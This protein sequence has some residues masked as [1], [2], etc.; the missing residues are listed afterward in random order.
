M[1]AA[2]LTP[3]AVVGIG[4]SA[5]GLQAYTELLEALPANTGMTF[6]IVQHMAAGHESFLSTLLGRIASMPV[7]EVLDGPQ[8][9]PNTIY[10]IPPNRTM[11]IT[12]GC[13][14]LRDRG[15]GIHFSVDIFFQ[16]LAMSHG[17]RAIGVVL[18][19]TGS[20]GAKGIEA[21]K[22]GGGTTFA[23]D[24]SAQQSGMPSSAIHTGCVDFVL[25]PR[26]IALEIATLAILPELAFSADPVEP[27]EDVEPILEIVR[28]RVRIDFSQYKENTLHRRI[29][30]RMALNQRENLTGYAA[31]LREK[32]TEV[33]ALAQD[34]LISVTSFFRDPESFEALKKT[35]FPRMLNR[36]SPDDTIR[37]WVVGCSTGEEP[38]SLAIALIEAMDATPLRHPIAVFG[39]DVNSQAIERAR[40]GWYPK[41][42]SEDISEE[43]LR[44][45]FTAV[46]GGYV[47]SKLIRDLCV[48]A[49]HNAITDPPF[50]R[51]DLVSCRNL[52]IYF[53]SGPQRKLLPLLHYALKPN[54]T[55][56][57]GASESINNYRDLFDQE[58][59]RHKIYVKRPVS[60]R[61]TETVPRA[62]APLPPATQGGRKIVRP[63]RDRQIER[64]RSAELVALKYFAPAGVLVDLD[65]EIHQFRGD[66]SPYVN[67]AEGRASLNL[68]KIAREG[69]FVAIRACL[70]HAS[71]DAA[72]LRNEGVIVK[73]DTGLTT[74]S[75][76]VIPVIYPGSD[77]RSAWI[78]FDQATSATLL[79]SDGAVLT[80]NA[81]L[82]ANTAH[83][84]T[85]LTDEL[86]ATRDHLEATIQEQEA[87]NE[88][89]QAANEEVQSSNEE[90]QSTNEELETSKEEIQSSNEEL[91]TV[92]DEL[93]LRNDEL[94]RANND[95]L[96]LFS[97]VQMA[98][99]MVWPDLRIRRFTPLAQTIFNI[100]PADVG[101]SIADMNHHIDIDDFTGLLREALDHGR[102]LEREVTS[103]EGYHYLLRL[104]PYR[105]QD[106]TID[107]AIVLLVDI[108]TLAQ[109]QA[110]LR[111]RV[112]ELA[113]S[114]RH[115]NEFLA[116]L[117]HE[118]RNPLAP[119]RNAVQ[120]LNRSPGDA[121]HTAKARGLIDRQVHH[122]SAPRERPAGCGALAERP[123]QITEFHAGSALLRRACDRPHAA[124]FRYQT[125]DPESRTAQ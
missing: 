12:D 75:I 30:R 87:A 103:K 120:I 50:S 90:L 8:V 22:A 115:R 109:T 106:G 117:A 43:R 41:S 84:I 68:L 26:D 107:G 64:N 57:L 99:V 21:I 67:Q 52:M 80:S 5:G 55:L 65:G 61:L 82:D 23:Q 3:V 125:T 69:L 97:S 44:R 25:A 118:L 73:N 114:D 70:L 110:S 35:A 29:R 93:R 104:R 31:L 94:D 58:D 2:A 116:V 51:M 27:L 42:I 71:T 18:S 33:E 123:D 49:P 79:H 36:K 47:V 56:L 14:V 60:L 54:G 101:R 7:V 72:P 112:A 121:A 11:V 77:E 95:L 91:S 119:L 37:V 108:N 76:I 105:A 39:T 98:V 4:A 16:A 88:D 92:N 89:L 15:P 20:D 66:T 48:F 100:R 102:D 34:I 78:F 86:M 122:M 113:D 111:A 62:P 38:Y 83:Q 6:V 59:A 24:Q 46:E 45:F 1:N 10:V 85:V 17:P 53:Q 19:G 40:R 74:V 9:E 96:N 13:L 63:I 32:P 124:Y 28:E 81:S